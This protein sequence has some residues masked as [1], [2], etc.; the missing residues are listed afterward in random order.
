LKQTSN[1]LTGGWPLAAVGL[2]ALANQAAQA[3]PDGAPWGTASPASHESCSNCH[4]DYEPVNDSRALRIDGLP[5]IAAPGAEYELVV[6]LNA[7]DASVSGFQLLALAEGMSAGS[8]R[9]DDDNVESIG[10]S[11]RS[12][13]PE[14]AADGA[15]W[16]LTWRAPQSDNLPIVMYLAANASNDDQS[17]LGD[18]I[19]YRTFV[20]RVI[21]EERESQ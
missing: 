1:T 2:I 13:R 14:I 16:S 4:Y 19:H 5:R 20:V 17:P 7:E 18:T 21:H 10:S 8:F 9:S 6:R 3:Y 12:T 11:T 15:A